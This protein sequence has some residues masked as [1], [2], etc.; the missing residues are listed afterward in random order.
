[1]DLFFFGG[2]GGGGGSVLRGGFPSGTACRAFPGE[3]RYVSIVAGYCQELEHAVVY[4]N[5]EHPKH[6]QWVTCPV[7]KAGQARTGMFSAS[8]NCV[9]ILATWGRALSSTT[10]T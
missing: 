3:E 4:A 2:G 1:M 6:A 8:R 5:P 9:L 7:M 10:L